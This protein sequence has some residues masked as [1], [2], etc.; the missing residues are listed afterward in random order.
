M[1]GFNPFSTTAFSELE[2]AQSYSL[3]ADAGSYTITGGSATFARIRV[4][5]GSAGSYAITGQ[6]AT[7]D[8]NPAVLTNL[9]T[10][11]KL[12]SFTEHRRF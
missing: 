4:I 1:Y 6:D 10:L 7:F 12:R 11:I 5:N 9:E 2:A 3:S 8:Y